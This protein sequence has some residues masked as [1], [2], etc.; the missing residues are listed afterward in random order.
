MWATGADVWG[1]MECFVQQLEEVL[2]DVSPPFQLAVIHTVQ[3]CQRRC[4][5]E[6]G[7]DIYSV[8]GSL[9]ISTGPIPGHSGI[10]I[11]RFTR[12]VFQAEELPALR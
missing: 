4:T 12:V 11:S 6:H 9:R 1:V 10:W 2:G 7:Q 3:I 8:P 5:T